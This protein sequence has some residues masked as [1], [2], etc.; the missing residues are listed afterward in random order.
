MAGDQRLVIA[1]LGGR[2]VV[3]R[4]VYVDPSSSEKPMEF[5]S[6]AGRTIV[7]RVE[8]VGDAKVAVTRRKGGY[9]ARV[10]IPWKSIGEAVPFRGGARRADA[11]VIFGDA[12]GTRV[13]RR[14]YLFDD[15]G[16]EVSDIPS[17]VRINPAAWGTFDF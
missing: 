10:D 7:Q 15:G 1:P 13:V 6:P 8:E 5:V 11:G 9:S 17:E 3:M 12:T 4:Y 2:L 14:Q 16:Q